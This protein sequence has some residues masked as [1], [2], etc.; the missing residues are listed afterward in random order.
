MNQ[1]SL[2]V[3]AHTL[4]QRILFTLSAGPPQDLMDAHGFE[5]ETRSTFSDAQRSQDLLKLL[6]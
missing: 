3:D 4:R 2:F 1:R 5:L 6:L